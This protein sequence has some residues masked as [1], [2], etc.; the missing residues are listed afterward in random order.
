M[1]Y[2]TSAAE[3]FA[4][5]LERR[6]RQQ[7]LIASFGRYALKQIGRPALMQEAARLAAEGLNASFAKVLE[8]EPGTDTL[9]VRAGVGWGPGVID[10]V[11]FPPG[12][13]SPAGYAFAMG[14]PTF[15][16]DLSTDHRFGLP[17]LLADNGIRREVNVVISGETGP[18]FGILEV[19]DT[20]DGVF[21]DDDIYYLESLANT[22]GLALE[23]DRLNAD[24]DRLLEERG[25]LLSE[26]HHRVKNS[27]Q[28]V[29]T[30]LT[31]QAKDAGDAT[32]RALLELSAMRVLT[33]ATV[34]ERLYQGDSFDTVE[35]QAYLLGLVEALRAG[36]RDI[37][38]GRS[39]SLDAGPG[40]FWPP[41]RAQALG[42][43]LTELVTNALKYGK[44]EVRV[45]F[46][47]TVPPDGA[48]LEVEDDGKPPER[49]TGRSGDGVGLR[50][51][52]ALL[53][54]HSGTLSFVSRPDGTHVVA[55]FAP[56][57]TAVP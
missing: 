2:G 36:L 25:V 29:Y 5:L 57:T 33:I 50:I 8:H 43:I 47:R 14:V 30:V 51:V 52:R 44:G 35:M 13:T 17:K 4:L 12:A 10:H 3:L 16:N 38:P 32:T 34:H 41:R 48:R 49:D 23:R 20:A 45:R 11:R 1:S 15:S 55:E 31:L 26:V 56:E 28:L 53:D 27:L 54:E 37:E 46:A 9:I 19:D 39:I 40:T 22:L 42:L 21:S 7:V 18:P 6:T 24:R